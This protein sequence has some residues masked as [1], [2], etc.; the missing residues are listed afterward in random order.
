MSPELAVANH[1][2]GISV[3]GSVDLRYVARAG[4]LPE[5]SG[6]TYDTLWKAMREAVLNSLDAGARRVEIDLSSVSTRKELVVVDD[7]CGMSTA[8]FCEHFMSLGGSSKFGDSARFGRIGIGSLALLQ[9]AEG[10]VIETKRAGAH[11]FTRAELRHPWDFDRLGRASHLAELRAGVA[12]EICYDGDASDHFTRLRLQGVSREVAAV[13]SDI[14][15]FYRLVD[16]L[17]RVLPLPWAGGPLFDALG[18]HAPEVVDAIRSHIAEWSA[19]VVIHAPWEREIGLTRRSYGDDTSGTEGW[20]GP[21]APIFKTLSVGRGTRRKLLIVGYLLNQLRA[22]ASWSGI[23]ARVQN[24]AVEEQTFFEV[25]G[26]PGFRK[27]ISGEIWL[28]GDIAR[29]RLINIDRASFNR[30]SADYH[31]VQRFMS[32]TIA[33][34]KAER[35]QRPQRAKVEIRRVIHERIAT[36][37]SIERAV[38]SALASRPDLK[39]LPTSESSR[40]IRGERRTL[41]TDLEDLAA[42]VLISDL[43]T[44]HRAG[45]DLQISGQGDS[46]Q[47][48]LGRRLAEPR[49][50]AGKYFYSLEFVAGSAAGPAIII[51]RRPRRIVVNVEHPFHRRSGRNAQTSL[52]LELAYLLSQGDGAAGVYEHA[53]EILS[54]T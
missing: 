38:E 50:R 25:T 31:A 39:E 54:R 4:L 24:V 42:E 34:F 18:E 12:S 19:P 13:G 29:E 17:R 9:H 30:A 20:A 7:G 23:T 21:P 46:V 37:E 22:S 27:Y 32:Q 44:A 35:V 15:K 41:Q 5:L 47:A 33:G 51:R 48:I 49:V 3:G 40:Q 11:V 36:I 14:G 6:Q 1:N 45:Y 26:D 16:R 2:G 52:A 8:E 53:I 43:D 10:A 28:L